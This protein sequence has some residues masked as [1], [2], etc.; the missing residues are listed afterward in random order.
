MNTM[1][2]NLLHTNFFNRQQTGASGARDANYSAPFHHFEGLQ[3]YR[4]LSRLVFTK[5]FER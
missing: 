5:G 2:A 1:Q 4:E 3:T